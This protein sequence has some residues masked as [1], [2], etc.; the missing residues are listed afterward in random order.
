MRCSSKQPHNALSAENILD[1]GAYFSYL[2]D[3]V[4]NKFTPKSYHYVFL[5]YSPMHKGYTC[6]HPLSKIVY[7]S[8]HIIFYEK[9]FPYANPNLL[10]SHA[11]ENSI[12]FLHL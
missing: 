8:R 3:Y 12:F 2:C 7:L 5:G 4:K 10:F 1:V 11:Q 6:L 9:I